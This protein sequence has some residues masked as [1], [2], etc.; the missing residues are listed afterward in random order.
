MVSLLTTVV[1]YSLN[2]NQMT[3][4]KCSR[5]NIIML[6]VHLDN[7]RPQHHTIPYFSLCSPFALVVE[8]NDQH[9]FSF[10]VPLYRCL[11]SLTPLYFFPTPFFSVSIT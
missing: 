3:F 6:Q 7:L 4:G 10:L 1:R 5:P 11:T 9:A 2:A 8:V